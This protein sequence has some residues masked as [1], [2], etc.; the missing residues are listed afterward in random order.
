M[1]ANL[2]PAVSLDFLDGYLFRL[3][4]EIAGKH[5]LEDSGFQNYYGS[6]L[7]EKIGGLIE[8]EERLA[9]YLLE[10]YP[11]HR[12]VHAGIGI[13]VLACALVCKGVTVAGVEYYP[14]R[15]ASAHY[16][17]A[18]LIEIW[19]EIEARYEIIEGSYPDALIPRDKPAPPTSRFLRW[20][21]APK[22]PAAAPAPGP[23]TRGP[24]FNSNA[25]LVF[26]NVASSWSDDKLASIIGSFPRFAEVLLDL[27]LFGA[28]RD[29]DRKCDDLF[30]RIAAI[31][32]S[33]EQLPELAIGS[34][35][36]RFVFT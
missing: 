2:G 29:T 12:V 15:V 18:A 23:L 3:L 27:R 8:Y 22:P 13:G 21:R 31:A 10:G 1:R 25:I 32:R 9:R 4:Q 5:G 33:A 16:L 36:A 24:W 17:R 20:R 26:T 11:G 28:V 6:R 35:F 14:K 19:P 30:N 34:H 7:T